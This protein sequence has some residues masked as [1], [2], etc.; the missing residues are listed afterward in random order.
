MELLLMRHG[1]ADDAGAANGFQ[2]ALR[3]LTPE[4]IS[5]MTTQARGMAALK[6]G[7]IDALLSSPLRRCVETAKIVGEAIGLEPAVD[8]R[9][10]PGARFEEIAEILDDYPDAERIAV[11]GHQPDLS[12]ITLDLTG[13][14]AEFKK[15]SVAVIE[16]DG[17]RRGGG[18]LQALFT[19]ASL[20]MVGAA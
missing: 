15:G 17:V 2:D 16:L 20:R 1:I 13:G 12:Y 6:L 19:P 8:E 7:A 3:A 18:C 11:C 9:L 5:R 14:L 4:G 10:A